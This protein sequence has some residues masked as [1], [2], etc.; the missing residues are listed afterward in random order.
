LYVAL[1]APIKLRA[2]RP[3]AA[4]QEGNRLIVTISS[5]SNQLS[6]PIHTFDGIDQG[7]G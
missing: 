4:G 3:P 7:E 6:S 1:A 2:G 5:I